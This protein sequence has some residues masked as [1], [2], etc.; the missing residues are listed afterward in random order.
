MSSCVAR[1]CV[2]K[3]CT[4]IFFVL[5]FRPRPFGHGNPSAA[6]GAQPLDGKCTQPPLKIHKTHSVLTN[7]PR[8]HVLSSFLQIWYGTCTL[9]TQFIWCLEQNTHTK[10][11]L[12][13]LG[14]SHLGRSP[15]PLVGVRLQ[16]GKGS[17]CWVLRRASSRPGYMYDN[18][19]WMDGGR[20]LALGKDFAIFF[21]KFWDAFGT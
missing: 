20:E 14:I 3:E 11:V 4:R 9:S 16:A 17:P 10:H 2:L 18:A 8:R 15:G 1:E 6:R 19:G 7:T 12:T 5:S 21:Q 13:H